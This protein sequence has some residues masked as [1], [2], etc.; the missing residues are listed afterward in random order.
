MKMIEERRYCVDILNAVTAIRGALKKV[1]AGILKD[2]LHACA[3]H[4]F[5]GKSRREKEIKLE[6]IYGLFNSLRK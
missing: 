6:E 5:D 1:E 2:H 4:A 3:R